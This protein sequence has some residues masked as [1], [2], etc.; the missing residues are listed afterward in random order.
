MRF[1]ISLLQGQVGAV[2]LL[3]SH[4]YCHQ[5]Y[6][7]PSRDQSDLQNTSFC[8]GTYL[9]SG[10]IL[11]T[12]SIDL[13]PNNLLQHRSMTPNGI[14]NAG[15]CCPSGFPPRTRPGRCPRYRPSSRCTLPILRRTPIGKTL[16]IQRAFDT[17]S[18]IL[19]LHPNPQ[20]KTGK[21]SAPS[22]LT[23]RGT[24]FTVRSGSPLG[25]SGPISKQGGNMSSLFSACSER[26]TLAALAALIG[27]VL[28]ALLVRRDRRLDQTGA[29]SIK[30]KHRG[31]A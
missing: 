2:P 7:N 14:S 13:L 24:K 6:K 8:P 10:R 9:I 23:E 4:Y 28:L 19:S 11:R 29:Q 3:L 20:S 5:A 12:A 17:Q 16:T 31:C 18:G 27:T 1:S 15:T 30:L 26:P 22:R 21:P 25:F